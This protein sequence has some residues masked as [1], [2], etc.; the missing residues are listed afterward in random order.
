MK[1]HIRM[2]SGGSGFTLIEL[3]IALAI[4]ALLT[5]VALPAY[6]EHIIKG[7][8]AEGQAALMAAIQLQ[9]RAYTVNG[10]YTNNAGFPALYGLA[11]A[12]VRSGQDPAAQT[13][14]YTLTVLDNPA[15]CADLAECVTIQAAPVAALLTDP[16]C[17]TMTLN[18]RGE[19]T[20]S[21]N[22]DLAYCWR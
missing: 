18:T 1:K 5:A 20:E 22:K 21:G 6:T 13:G 16:S 11:A 3:M 10:R 17:G 8:R 9:E 15:G 7:K 14:Y 19:R 4:V 12:P 2:R